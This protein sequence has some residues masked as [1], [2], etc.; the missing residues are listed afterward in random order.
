MQNKQT[1]MKKN[2]K[3]REKINKILCQYYG[4]NGVLLGTVIDLESLVNSEVEDRLRED[5][6]NTKREFIKEFCNDHDSQIRWL[7][8]V[9][10]NEQHLLDLILEF[11]DSRVQQ[12]KCK[13]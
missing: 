10:F 5:R 11:L 2:N 4:E 9:A 6:E 12:L 8:G 7:R 1:N 3:L 13:D